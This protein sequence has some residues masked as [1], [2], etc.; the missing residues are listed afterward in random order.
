VVTNDPKRVVFYGRP[1][2]TDPAAYE[3]KSIPHKVGINPYVNIGFCV[4][5]A[6]DTTAMIVEQGLAV[7][8]FADAYFLNPEAGTCSPDLALLSGTNPFQLAQ[9]LLRLGTDLVA[10]RPLMAAVLSPGGVGSKTKCC[11]KFNPKSVPSVSAALSNVTPNRIKVNT[12]LFS[13]TATAKS[14]NDPVNGTKV[15]LSTTVNSGTNSFIKVA[16]SSGPCSSG[17]VP[18]GI[19]GTGTNPAGTVVF[20]N[21]CFTNTGN[22]YVL[23][24][25][26]VEDRKDAPVTVKSNKIISYP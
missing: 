20:N 22:I 7:L 3:W 8:A 6:T 11:S 14:G 15:T 17:T 21:L 26:N 9:R 5:Q 4:N 2:T 1:V 16:P 19:T 23:G 12:Q 13:I 25:F 18:E 24:L 10:P